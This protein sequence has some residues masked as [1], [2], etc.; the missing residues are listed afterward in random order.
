M[1]VTVS[2]ASKLSEFFGCQIED[3]FPGKET[4]ARRSALSA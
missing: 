3:L 4:A 2:T 1:T